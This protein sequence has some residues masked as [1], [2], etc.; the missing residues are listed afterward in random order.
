[1]EDLYVCVYV[2]NLFTLTVLEHC[3][4]DSESQ[5]YE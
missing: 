4:G 5:S 2:W 3:A 1:M